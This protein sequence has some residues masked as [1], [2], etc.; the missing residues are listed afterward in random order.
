[1]E[2]VHTC[3]VND[4]TYR[5]THKLFQLQCL[6]SMKQQHLITIHTLAASLHTKQMPFT[7]YST[8]PPKSSRGLYLV[9]FP[10]ATTLIHGVKRPALYQTLGETQGHASVIRPLERKGGRGTCDGNRNR[11]LVEHSPVQATD[12]TSLRPLC[13]SWARTS[14][15]AWSPQWCPEHPPRPGPRG[16]L[17]SDRGSP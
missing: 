9:P 7:V 16:C 5:Y 3:V 8:L 14:P 4:Y 11:L 1:M 15:V 10:V 17:E 12:G 13:P 2:L 6:L